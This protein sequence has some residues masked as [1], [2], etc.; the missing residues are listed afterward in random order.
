LSV[1]AT[2][3]YRAVVPSWLASRNFDAASA[4]ADASEVAL[5]RAGDEDA[6]ETLV[7]RHEAEVYRIC[8]RLLDD[9]EDALDATQEVFLRAFRGLARFR[10]AAT[11]RT[12]L[13]GIAVNACRSC[14]VTA[15]HRVRRRTV[16]LETAANDGDPPTELPLPDPAPS[17][18]A[19][20]FGGELRRA[21]SRA[22]ASVSAEHREALVLREIEGLD[23]AEIALVLGVAVGTVKSRLA[24]ARAALRAELEGVWP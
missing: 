10:G 2:L 15:E 8:R 18:E 19:H 17:P 22:L 11:F 4:D 23:Y 12:W 5:A 3:A 6:F 13:V 24:R 20:A 1:S 9:S 7:S 16:G 14:L 21:L